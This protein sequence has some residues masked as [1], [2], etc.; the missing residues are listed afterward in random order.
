MRWMVAGI[1]GATLLFGACSK[2]GDSSQEAAVRAAVEAHLQKKSNLA[3]NNMD[4][5][6]QN[7]KVNGDA[8]D[9][10]VK[11]SSKQNPQ[12]AVSIQYSLRRAGN[13]WEVVSSMP[14]GGDSHQSVTPPTAHGQ[15]AT[16]ASSAPQPAKP[17][18]SH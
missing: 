9:A 8:A 16:G 3:L 5:Q 14:M 7:V 4:M 12:L 10:Q 11:F 17:E 18:A 6:I 2:S 13:H 15:D 1:V